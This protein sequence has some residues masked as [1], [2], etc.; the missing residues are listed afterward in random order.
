MS[1]EIAVQ[2]IPAP[3]VRGA[4]HYEFDHCESRELNPIP[5]EERRV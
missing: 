4:E 1:D 3:N 5:Q 2:Q